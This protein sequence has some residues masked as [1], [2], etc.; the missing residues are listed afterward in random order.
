MC[1]QEKALVHRDALEGLTF[2]GAWCNS[3]SKE[4]NIGLGKSVSY[5]VL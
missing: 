5:C 3:T 2:A 4:Q 1:F